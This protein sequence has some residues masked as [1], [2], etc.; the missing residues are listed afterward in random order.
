MVRGL[1]AKDRGRISLSYMGRELV[2]IDCYLRPAMPN[3]PLPPGRPGLPGGRGGLGGENSSLLV[4]AVFAIDRQKENSF[5]RRRQRMCKCQQNGT[6]G[7]KR[8]VRPLLRRAGKVWP[9]RP[10]AAASSR[11]TSFSDVCADLSPLA[12]RVLSSAGKSADGSWPTPAAFRRLFRPA[13]SRPSLEA[14]LAGSPT[15]G[16]LY[17][18]T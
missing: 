13:S 10:R 7:F 18:Y 9:R 1:G 16:G 6:R 17:T 8:R 14:S 11:R 4:D 5:R 2:T 15:A 12:E 3:S